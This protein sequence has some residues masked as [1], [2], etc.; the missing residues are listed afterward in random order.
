MIYAQTK[1]QAHLRGVLQEPQEPEQ[2]SNPQ[3]KP[4]YKA[5]DN[6]AHYTGDNDESHISAAILVPSEDPVSASSKSKTHEDENCHLHVNKKL[7]AGSHVPCKS[8][9]LQHGG[10][11]QLSQK[12]KKGVMPPTFLDNDLDFMDTILMGL[13]SIDADLSRPDDV[14]NL[15]DFNM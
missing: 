6:D 10:K 15:F 2:A 7:K 11:F 8:D 14:T 13:D 3:Q 4:Q 5:H 9:H 1:E 12:G